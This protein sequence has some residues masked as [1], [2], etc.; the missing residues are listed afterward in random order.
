MFTIHHHGQSTLSCLYL[1]P[2]IDLDQGCLLPE[3][4]FR[5][6]TN[7]KHYRFHRVPENAGICREKSR[8]FVD[9]DLKPTQSTGISGPKAL[10]K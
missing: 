4:A 3:V 5:T 6:V 8:P 1:L 10:Q 2:V 9:F 7:E